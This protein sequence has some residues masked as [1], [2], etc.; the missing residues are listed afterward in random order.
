MLDPT[1]RRAAA[2]PLEVLSDRE[3]Q[4]FD[5]IL[6]G[7]GNKEIAAQLYISLKTVETHRTHIMKKLRLHSILDVIRFAL[8]HGLLVG[9]P[10]VAERDA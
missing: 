1:R 5:L 9:Q 10:R 7:L 8:Q 2:G 6:Q 3:K 4:V